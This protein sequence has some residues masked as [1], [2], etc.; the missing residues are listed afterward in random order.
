MQ[1]F[2]NRSRTSANNPP[3]ITVQDTPDVQMTSKPTPENG[4]ARRQRTS[5]HAN[6]RTRV[7]EV[8]FEGHENHNPVQLIVF[9]LD[10]TLTLATFSVST[11]KWEND[12]GASLPKEVAA[13]IVEHSFESPYLDGSR[14]QK[15]QSMLHDLA[16][17][18]SH[19][20]ALAILT[21]NNGGA[22][23]VLN[24]LMAARLANYFSAIWRT[25]L[26]DGRPCGVYKDGNAWK[27][28]T[29]PFNKVPDRMQSGTE[30][31]IQ[32]ADVLW[33]VSQNPAAWFPQLT[34]DTTEMEMLTYLRHE[35]IVLVDDDTSNFESVSLVD[36][37]HAA[38]GVKVLRYCKVARYD[39]NYRN[40]GYIQG[41]GGLGAHSDADYEHLK[42]FVSAPWR[43]K[44]GKCVKCVQQH[45]DDD[46]KNHFDGDDPVL[47]VVFD[48]DETLSL[49]TFMPNDRSHTVKIGWVPAD[50]DHAI[51]SDWTEEDLVRYNFES[52]FLEGSRVA[53]LKTMLDNIARIDGADGQCRTLA[54]L[55]RN[56]GGAVAVLNLLIAANLADHF[57]AVWGM[58]STLG[59][60]DSKTSN[61]DA[62]RPYGV[63]RTDD[64][65]KTFNPPLGEVHCHKADV[66]ADVA[67]NPAK[68]FP[69]L[70]NFSSLVQVRPA[71]IVL[72]DDE[73]I[74]FHSD[75][76]QNRLFRFC[77]V[78]RYDDTY[79]DCGFLNQM[80]GIGAHSDEDYVVLKNF[81]EEPWKYA[82]EDSHHIGSPEGITDGCTQMGVTLQIQRQVECDLLRQASPLEIAIHAKLPRARKVSL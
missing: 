34:K 66:I 74:N 2:F 70:V 43:H 58:P 79:R 4:Q 57:S 32:K 55:T 16:K 40:Y 1:R 45:S 21:N 49:A 75:A 42:M 12:I 67:K 24:F 80:G 10:E 53:K 65:W 15:L 68:W 13:K 26:G 27:K 23:G 3:E 41:L 29:P 25:D 82:E 5:T 30:R 64:G 28:F 63:Y 56:T 22:V 61:E 14:V 76:T 81:L 72:V 51:G 37:A 52:P 6:K 36:G 69:Q 62:T 11:S 78:A 60:N 19:P 8:W 71:Q 73:R 47:I 31:I 9:D 20:R 7:D 46:D 54:I 17:G 59:R 48:F 77:K 33:H 38:S 39:D 44:W 18:D 35:G 50:S